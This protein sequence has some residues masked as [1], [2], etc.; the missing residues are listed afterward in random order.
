M[1]VSPATALKQFR[2]FC[3]FSPRM[4]ECCWY[5]TNLTNLWRYAR[6]RMKVLAYDRETEIAHVLRHH[7]PN[8]GGAPYESGAAPL[9]DT[10]EWARRDA[11]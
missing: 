11:S 3:G 9:S 10:A 6:N 8:A 4:N 2:Y 7:A 1:L 5:Q